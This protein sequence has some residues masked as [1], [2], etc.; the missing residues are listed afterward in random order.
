MDDEARAL[1]RIAAGD[2]DALAPLYD[3]LAPALLALARRLC[4]SLED[5]EE[6]VQDVFVRLVQTADRYDPRLG[7]VRA[8][9]YTMVRNAVASLGRRAAARPVAVEVDPDGPAGAADPWPAADRRLLV[10]DALAVLDPLDRTL[11]REAYLE[12]RSH[13][14]L[15]DRHAMPLGTVKSRIR[16]AL[17]RL[18]V[19]LEGA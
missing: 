16:R 18:R 19:R 4:G 2:A 12:G 15:A 11:V 8:L 7:S 14:E 10:D 6:V 17:Q 3:A 1:R 5:A 9:A 13:A